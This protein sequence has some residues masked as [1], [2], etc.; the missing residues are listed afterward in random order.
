[1]AR[2][3]WNYYKRLEI[4]LIVT[5]AFFI[6]LF[7]ALPRIGRLPGKLPEITFPQ[8]E[9]LEIPRTVQ[10]MRRAS[11]PP[12]RPSIPVAGDE[13]EILD[14]IPLEALSNTSPEGEVTSGVPLSED[15]LPFIPRQTIEVLPRIED[16]NVKG[17]VVLKLL[18]DTTGKMKNYRLISNTTKNPLVEKR[19]L[20][21]ARKSRWEVIHLN[22]NKVE[23]WITKT[24]SF[25]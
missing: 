16:L 18:I 9:V 4:S 5:L 7:W 21:A 23:Y 12:V 22:N 15:D 10:K 11:P 3:K 2:I 1:M 6:L 20:D 13:I 14:E 24:Y 8:I 17:E 25:R 19:V